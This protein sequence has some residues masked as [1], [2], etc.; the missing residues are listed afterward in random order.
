MQGRKKILISYLLLFICC[1]S[2]LTAQPNF[3][4]NLSKTKVGEQEYLQAEYVVENANTLNSFQAPV[5]DG[6]RI[7][8]FNKPFGKVIN[9]GK[10]NRYFAFIYTLEPL[11]AGMYNI[12]PAIAK[13]DG[14]LLSSKPLKIQV[15]NGPSPAKMP[16]GLMLISLKPKGEETLNDLSDYIVAA[17]E[18]TTA[19]IN[20]QVYVK[21]ETNRTVLFVGEPLLTTYKFYTHLNSKADIVKRPS[22]NGFSVYE[23]PDYGWNIP[24]PETLNRRKYNVYTIRKAQLFP[25][26]AGEAELEGMEIQCLTSLIRSDVLKNSDR[27]NSE[28][29]IEQYFSNT[30]GNDMLFSHATLVKTEPLKIVVKELPEKGKPEKFSGAVGNFS[31]DATLSTNRFETGEA[32][33]LTVR[34]KGSGNMP[35]IN[36]PLIEWPEGI[37]AFEPKTKEQYDPVSFPLTGEKSFEYSFVPVKEGSLQIP[38]I[39]F[40]FFDPAAQ[41]YRLLNTSALLMEVKK[42]NNNYK[43]KQGTVADTRSNTK[44]FYDMI[45]GPWLLLLLLLVPVYF[46]IKWNRRQKKKDLLDQKVSE[47]MDGEEIIE[48]PVA[49]AAIV[50]D[51]LQNSRFVMNESGKTFYGVLQNELWSFFEKRFGITAAS[52]NKQQLKQHLTGTKLQPYDLEQTIGIIIL[53]ESAVYSPVDPHS[54]HEGVLRETERIIGLLS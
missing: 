13:A 26:Q 54:D 53:C 32:V 34:I 19:K 2:R 28:A 35:V 43:G 42:G 15:L 49:A 10:L 38:V 39:G 9:N 40:N 37:E 24:Q 45:G 17:N 46:I 31:I 20:R 44:K 29:L 18:D 4:T 3:V 6:F 47:E 51:P 36:A 41:Q 16:A 25:L 33:T 48:E 30:I 12:D 14:Q 11:K 8:A 21:A 52:R 50:T 22:F 23:M 1:F 5:F 7:I 27:I